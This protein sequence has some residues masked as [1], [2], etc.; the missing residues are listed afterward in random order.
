MEQKHL[1]R[2]LLIKKLEMEQEIEKRLW[3][4]IDNRCS[5]EE[6]EIVGR[7]LSQDPVWQ[8]KYAELMGVHDLLQKEDLDMPSLRFTKNV[9]EEIA[10]YQVAPATQNYINKNVIRGIGLFLLTLVAGLFIYIT[11][12]MN[13]NSAPTSHFSLPIDTAKL[14]P[15]KFMNN[16]VV[17]VFTGL[18]VVLSLILLDQFLQMKKK[19]AGHGTQGGTA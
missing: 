10:K 19:M 15:E 7:L 1:S 11:K 2:N 5:P 13:W 8:M 12:S 16:T 3:D 18:T 4:Y 14:N 17:L 9:M 6:K